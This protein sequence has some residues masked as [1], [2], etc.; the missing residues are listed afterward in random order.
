MSTGDSTVR[1]MGSFSKDSIEAVHDLAFLYSAP[2]SSMTFT[3]PAL[4]SFDGP[5]RSFSGSWP[6]ADEQHVLSSAAE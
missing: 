2:C 3:C 1:P 6:S 4:L 5:A